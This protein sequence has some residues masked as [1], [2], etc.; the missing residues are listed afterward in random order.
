MPDIILLNPLGTEVFIKMML[1]DPEVGP[2]IKRGN[3]AGMQGRGGERLSATVKQR[4]TGVEECYLE[5]REGSP[6][7]RG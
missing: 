2:S 6:C 5:T 4:K 3:V 7:P 1:F